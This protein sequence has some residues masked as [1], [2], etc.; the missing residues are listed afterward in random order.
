[1]L[2][3]GTGSV[4]GPLLIGDTATGLATINGGSALTVSNG[5][6]IVGDDATGFGVLT[7]TALNSSLLLPAAVADFIVGNSGTG[8]ALIENF[9]LV[10]VADDLLVGNLA[11]SSGV[12]FLDGLGTLADVGDQVQVGQAGEGVLEV[13][14][15]ARLFADDTVVGTLAT[16]DGRVTITGLQS[17]WRQTNSMIV[18][19]FGHGTLEVFDQARLETTNLVAGNS[20]DSN[21]EMTVSG[22]AN[23][24]INGFMNLS[25]FGRSR[26]NI[27]D[28]GRVTNTTSVRLATQASGESLVVVSGAQSLWDVGTSLTVGEMG[29]G[30]VEVL[31]GGHVTTG[32]NVVLGDVLNSRG[33]VTVD[34]LGSTLAIAGTLD[35][36]QPAEAKMTISNGG[37]VTATGALRVADAGELHLDGGRI[38]TSFAT[39][40]TNNGLVRGG[41]TIAAAVTNS[42]PGEIRVEAADSLVMTSNLINVGVIDVQFGEIEVLGPTTN[43]GDIDTRGG[44]LRFQNGLTNNSGSQLA[45]V[46]GEVD[47]FG[48]IMNA[49]GAQVVVGGEAHVAMHDPFTNNG[50]LLVTPGSE[51]LALENLTF[52][53]GAGL[54]VQLAGTEPANEFGQLNAAGTAAL[55]GALAVQLVDGFHPAAGD[56]FQIITAANGRSGIF[57]PENLPPLAGGLTWDVVYNPTSVVLNVIG[58]PILVGDY[59]NNGTVDAADYV[60]WRENNNTATTLPNDPT[61][62][63]DNSDYLAWRANFGATGSGAGAAVTVPEPG[64]II[65]IAGALLALATPCRLAR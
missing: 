60:V 17:L 50:S 49:L 19:D 56:T 54:T 22:E 39:G 2:P 6:A 62:G 12:F 59:N 36:S 13:T 5:S 1:M 27:L 40:L 26:L 53:G 41:G 11:N 31:N 64:A 24:E 46:G 65:L 25:V 52:G 16:G 34:G 10:N 21:G 38:S 43:S 57:S 28:A 63:V 48:N 45:V 3:A 47:I 9:G 44:V 32:G 58:S 23:W 7:I 35:V 42:S 33:E 8:N 4:A 15:G 37:L 51:L 61:P 18:A 30:T 29:F 20:A 14:E 55:A